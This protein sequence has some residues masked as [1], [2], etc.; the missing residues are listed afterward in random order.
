MRTQVRRFPTRP[1]LS[2][3][4]IISCG[5]GEMHAAEVAREAGYRVRLG[6]IYTMLQRLERTGY[7]KSYKVRMAH[8][9]SGTR[10]YEITKFGKQVLELWDQFLSISTNSSTK[11]RH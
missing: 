3:M 9:R 5:R 11:V 8:Q 10:Y 1:N 4:E 7:V 6:G 2:L